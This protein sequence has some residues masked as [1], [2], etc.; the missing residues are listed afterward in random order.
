MILKVVADWFVDCQHCDQDE[1]TDIFKLGCILILE[2][3][4]FEHY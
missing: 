1:S 2:S 3:L 4:Q